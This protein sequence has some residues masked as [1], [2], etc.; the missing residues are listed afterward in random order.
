MYISNITKGRDNNLDL[1]RFLAAIMVIF[2][3]AFP[4]SLGSENR[5][6]LLVITDGQIDFWG[7]AVSIF[8]FYGGF[9]ICKSAHRLQSARRYF[10]ARVVGIFPPIIVV[11]VLLAFI[12]G[13]IISR[14]SVKEYFMNTQTYK[15]LL[16][17]VVVLVHDL[18][19]VFEENIY[20]TTVNGPLWTMP[21]EFMGYILC[22]LMMKLGMLQ[23]KYIKWILPFFTLVHIAVIYLFSPRSMMLLT[24]RP[25]AL[26]FVGMLYYV[27]QDKIKIS[28][29]IALV[30]LILWMLSFWI[31]V[32]NGTIIL[33]LPYILMYLG[34]GTN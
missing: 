9:L 34:Y 30:S 18:P 10:K 13:P 20:G 24:W 4:L 22:F 11:T 3:H 1:I 19:G 7:I 32:A 17:S 31:G 15:Y 16:N 6:C 33:F 5:D 28:W 25:T 26:F 27:Y 21:V 14:L 12:V 29:N 23:L 2:S 8:F